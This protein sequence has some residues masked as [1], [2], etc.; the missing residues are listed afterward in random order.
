MKYTIGYKMSKNAT[1]PLSNHLQIQEKIITEAISN[2]TYSHPSFDIFIR[3][4][5]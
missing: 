4:L 5:F 3:L 1:K 2:A